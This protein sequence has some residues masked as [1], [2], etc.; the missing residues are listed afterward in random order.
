MRS[1]VCAAAT[2]TMDADAARAI[3]QLFILIISFLLPIC[4]APADTGGRQTS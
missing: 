2:V 4:S 3:S 1:S